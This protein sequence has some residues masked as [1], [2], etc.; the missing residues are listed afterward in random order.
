MGISSSAA[1]REAGN[2]WRR[3]LAEA[4]PVFSLAADRERPALQTFVGATQRFRLSSQ[5]S[6][7][8]REVARDSG[9]TL[10]DA[11]AVRADPV[12]RFTTLRATL[13]ADQLRAAARPLALLALEAAGHVGGPDVFPAAGD[14]LGG[15]G[16]PAA[17]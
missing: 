9:H 7:R 14:D 13:D 3:Q 1:A 5:T 8:L 12:E 2:Y 10:L 15:C 17:G 11:V 16:A 4:P 6:L